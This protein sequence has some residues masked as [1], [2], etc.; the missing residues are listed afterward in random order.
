MF[1]RSEAETQRREDELDRFKRDI[2]LIAFAQSHGY[3][4]LEQQSGHYARLAAGHRDE[5]VITRVR[6]RKTGSIVW[7]WCDPRFVVPAVP[8][9]GQ[10][11]DGE[12]PRS[13]RE[14]E[15]GSVVDFVKVK[16]GESNLGEVRKLLRKWSSDHRGDPSRP[17]ALHPTAAPD[18]EVVARWLADAPPVG[19]SRYLCGRGLRPET[20]SHWRFSDTLR[21]TPWGE[22]RFEHRD[23]RGLC[24]FERKSPSFSGFSPKGT[25]GLWCSRA[26]KSDRALMV[27]EATIECLSYQQLHPR[28]DTRYISTGGSISY[29]Q[30]Q[31]IAKAV[32]RLPDGATLIVATNNDAPGHHMATLIADIARDARPEI[33]ITRPLPPIGKDWND[34]LKVVERDFI[35]ASAIRL[36]GKG[37]H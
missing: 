25:R 32:T 18:R 37:L 22:A 9:G 20:L 29:E 5:I 7:V 23:H 31:L 36:R 2:D 11:R 35:N 4:I 24:G 27:S 1:V 34:T 15:Q 14:G 21:E 3:P 33:A 19:E 6:S 8:R 28:I 17:P 10:K 12:P 13:R 30:S 26:F 16:L